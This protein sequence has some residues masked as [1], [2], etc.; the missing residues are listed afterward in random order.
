MLPMTKLRPCA[1]CGGRFMGRD[2][3]KVM[4]EHESLAFFEGEKVCK[5]C[6]LNHG[7]L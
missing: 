1:G 2:L 6:A 7:V 4:D 5:E 3:Y